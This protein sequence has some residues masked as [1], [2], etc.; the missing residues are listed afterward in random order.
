VRK[1]WCLAA[2]CSCS[3]CACIAHGLMVVLLLQYKVVAFLDQARAAD[4]LDLSFV[5]SLIRLEAEMIQVKG[6]FGVCERI[7]MNGVCRKHSLKRERGNK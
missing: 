7:Y 5:R 6:V 1:L 3:C 2:W 4:A